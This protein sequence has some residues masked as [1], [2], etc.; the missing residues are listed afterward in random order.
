M[1]FPSSLAT[2]FP[3][4]VMRSVSFEF[5]RSHS[6]CVFFTVSLSIYLSVH[7]LKAKTLYLLSR[8]GSIPGCHLITKCSKEWMSR[9]ERTLE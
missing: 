8:F 6:D 3:P 1:H 9:D 2:F 7:V 4:S 5:K